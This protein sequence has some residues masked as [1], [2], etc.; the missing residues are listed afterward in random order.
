MFRMFSFLWSCFISLIGIKD[1]LRDRSERQYGR[2]QQQL[3]DFYRQQENE[4]IAHDIDTKI[5]SL[6]ESDSVKQLRQYFA[7]PE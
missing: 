2:T 6:P 7:R 1:W 5:D 3:D 4:R